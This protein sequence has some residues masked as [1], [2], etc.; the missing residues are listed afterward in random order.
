ML[1]EVAELVVDQCGGRCRD[2]H[3]SAVSGGGDSCCTVDVA[4]HVP[5]LRQKRRAGVQTHAYRNRELCLGLARRAEC[6]GRGREGDEKGIALRV[7]LDAVVL[8]ERLA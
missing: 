4:A 5:L 2:E 3:L 7:D 8:R 1:T 6:A